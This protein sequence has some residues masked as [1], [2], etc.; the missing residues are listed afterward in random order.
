MGI[1]ESS[2]GSEQNVMREEQF[3]RSK[4]VCSVLRATNVILSSLV[5]V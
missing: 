3:F 1:F 5:K 4:G 2:V